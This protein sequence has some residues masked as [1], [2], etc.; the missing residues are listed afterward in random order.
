MGA[1]RV[2]RDFDGPC[3]AFAFQGRD[4]TWYRVCVV[5]DALIPRSGTLPRW[6][7]AG[8]ASERD[9]AMGARDHSLA[10]DRNRATDRRFRAWQAEIRDA[11]AAGDWERFADAYDNNPFNGRF[12]VANIRDDLTHEEIMTMWSR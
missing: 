8:Y 1:V 5:C 10:M 9:A 4:G 11:A 7:G 6:L 3:M 2:R 12:K